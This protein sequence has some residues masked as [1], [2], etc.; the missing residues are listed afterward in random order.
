MSKCV[1]LCVFLDIAGVLKD[2]PSQK[3]QKCMYPIMFDWKMV[4]V[5]VGGV[6]I[7]SD[8]SKCVNLCVFLDIAGVLKDAPSQKHQKCMYPIMFDWK[9][10][11]VFVGGVPI[12]SDVSKCVNLCVF[13]D[14]AGVLKDAPSQK[15]QKCMYPIMFD[16]KMVL[17]FVGGVPMSSDVSKC[18]N[19]CVFL[20]IAGVSNNAPTQKYH[21]C[22]CHVMFDWKMV[23]V[24]VGGVPMSSDVSKCVN[25]CV[26]LD[27]AGVLKDAPSQKHQKCMYPIMFDW[28]M[29]LVLVGG[30]LMSSDMLF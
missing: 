14:I 21:I 12:S 8:V 16:W 26:F 5:F 23:L 19:F 18:V 24:F 15:H 1:N 4:L 13:L 6:P 17:V 10:V 30:V 29:V 25:L 2:A 3:H 22:V 9:M 20:D 7:S 28:K 27:I 11:L